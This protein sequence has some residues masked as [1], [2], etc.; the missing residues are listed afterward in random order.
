MFKRKH[1]G[2]LVGHAAFL[3]KIVFSIDGEGNTPILGVTEAIL[4]GPK[5]TYGRKAKGVNPLSG[6]GWELRY[7]RVKKYK[8]VPEMQLTI[9]SDACP[10]TCAEAL[11]LVAHT[12]RRVS[13]I[14]VSSLELTFDLLGEE[15]TKLMNRVFTSSRRPADIRE[16]KGTWYIGSPM[17]AWEV[18]IYQKAPAVCRLEFILRRSFLQKVGINDPVEILGLRH[19]DLSRVLSLRRLDSRALEAKLGSI[20]PGWKRRLVLHWP[21]SLQMHEQGLRRNRKIETIEAFPLARVWVQ[22]I[23]SMQRRLIW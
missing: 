18:R 12:C 23:V 4:S 20:T 8:N 13:R 5:S 15:P 1:F 16:F 10:V 3:H 19:F 11:M 6:N 7:G 14:Q 22:R 21:Y 17:S 9:R 2:Y